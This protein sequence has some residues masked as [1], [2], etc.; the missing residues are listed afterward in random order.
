MTQYE[1][2]SAILAKYIPEPAIPQI[3]EWIVELDF[4]L[5]IKKERSTKLGDYR[6]PT[7]D[8]NHQITINYNLN[9][10]AFLVTLLHEIAHLTTY[11][12]YQNSVLPHGAEWKR[13][14]QIIMKDF[15]RPGVFPDDVI[16]AL[17]RYLVNPAAASCSD[18]NLLRTLKRYDHPEKNG[19][20]VFLETLPYQCT[21][22]YNEDRLFIKGERIRT[23]YRCK[24][25]ATGNIYLFNAVAEVEALISA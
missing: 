4:K 25:V 19:N 7:Y 5:K 6:P 8:S 14:Y 22:K 13:E 17:R 11:N 20:L 12:K 9:K 21:F 18:K 16:S 1:R 15:L 24:E 10:Y 2:N 23:R 3:A